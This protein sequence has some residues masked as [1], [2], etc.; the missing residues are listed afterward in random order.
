MNHFE[1]PETLARADGLLGAEALALM[2]L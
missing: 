2:G 1:I